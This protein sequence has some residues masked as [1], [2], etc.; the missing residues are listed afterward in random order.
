MLT[1]YGIK[2]CDKV[3]KARKFL[4]THGIKYEFVDFKTDPIGCQTIDKWLEHVEIE[5]LFNKRSTTYR[6]LN[7][8]THKLDSDGMRQW[9]CKENM[10]IKRPVLETLE[11]DIIVGFDEDL[12]ERL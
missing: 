7:L 11:G 10:L 9:L 3:R 8:K 6:N 2:N 12:Y 5:K 1:L 4:D